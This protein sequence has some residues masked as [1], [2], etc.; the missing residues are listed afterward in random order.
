MDMNHKSFPVAPALLVALLMAGTLPVRAQSAVEIPSGTT[1]NVR[2]ID[3]LSS[4]VNQTGDTFHGTLDDPIELN[5]RQLYPK[6]ADV[7]GR[8]TDV[9]PTGRL[10][11][12]GELD[13]VLNT[14]SSGTV[15]ASI[16]V[17]PLVIKGE[18]HSK[19]NVTKIGG[20]AALGAVIGAIAGGGKGAAIGTLAGGAAG[21]GAAAATGKKPATVD[22]EAIL[23]FVTSTASSPTAPL[24][25]NSNESAPMSAPPA[26][27]ANSGSTNAGSTNAA[28]PNSVSPQ[29]PSNQSGVNQDVP[30]P[31]STSGTD[32]AS[33]LFT[34]RDRRIIRE[35]VNEHS[36][37]LPAAATQ[38]PELPSGAE[39]QI[40]RG[41]ILSTEIQNAAQ[42]LPLA[43]EDQLPKLPSDLER[44][45]YSG[46]VLLID[47]KGH[48]IDMFPLDQSQ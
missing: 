40:R 31:D 46:R 13:L 6:G 21:T 26:G 22:S 1:I 42:A 32:D 20:G 10:S 24:P 25:A 30:A 11:E 43:C 15:A 4:E 37:D 27:S 28:S 5:G 8:V 2:M 7:I 12:P 44:V 41:G 16:H 17:Q 39:R 33:N 38:R 3:K 47:S 29:T 9:H 36:S 23:T 48:V 19:S 34:L 18:S 45:V 14:V 35:C